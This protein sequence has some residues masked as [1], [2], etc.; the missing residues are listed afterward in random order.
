[1]GGLLGSGIGMAFS[2]T[3]APLILALTAAAPASVLLAARQL[4]EAVRGGGGG[5]ARG[6]REVRRQGGVLLGALS[7]PS[8]WM[9]LHLFL[10]PDPDH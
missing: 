5:G 4:R 6:V 10:F 3:S 9:P 2:Q 8:V 7:L 1:M